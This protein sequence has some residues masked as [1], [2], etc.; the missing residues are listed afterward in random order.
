MTDDGFQNFDFEAKKL[1]GRNLKTFMRGDEGTF[2]NGV[3]SKKNLDF[4]VPPAPS[5]EK[6]QILG[7]TARSK[8]DHYFRTTNDP[9]DR[10]N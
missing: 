1:F 8:N 10:K 6:K 9:L 2:K 4:F 7:L 5:R 3:Y